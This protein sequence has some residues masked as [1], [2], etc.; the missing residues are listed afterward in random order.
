MYEYAYGA[1]G[2][3]W[4]IVYGHSLRIWK[5]PVTG[6]WEYHNGPAHDAV[7]RKQLQRYPNGLRP[8]G[9]PKAP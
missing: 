9:L 1:L 3:E 2:R 4:V 6:T 5:T 7:F 8:A